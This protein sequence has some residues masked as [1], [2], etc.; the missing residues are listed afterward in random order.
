M[1][2][3]EAFGAV[4]SAYAVSTGDGLMQ[5]P[6]ADKAMRAQIVAGLARAPTHL[7]TVDAGDL[8]GNGRPVFVAGGFHADPPWD[9]ISRVGVWRRASPP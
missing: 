5:R 3:D 7:M 4:R 9:R 1:D 8:D 2:F 6:L